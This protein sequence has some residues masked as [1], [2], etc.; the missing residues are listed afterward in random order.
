VSAEIPA[1]PPVPVLRNN[2][3]SCA[4]TPPRTG[5]R[6]VAYRRCRDPL[7]PPLAFFLVLF[8]GW[9]NRHQQAVI[10]YLLEENRILR[11]VIAPKT[12][13]LGPGRV[14]CRERLGG[15]LRFYREAA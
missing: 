11:A 5:L 12:T 8:S 6:K 1:I 9:V 7:P 14:R 3:A 4:K 15:V 13:L 2:S 10:E